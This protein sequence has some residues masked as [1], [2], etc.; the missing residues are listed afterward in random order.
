MD[1]K[2]NSK[3]E[4]ENLQKDFEELYEYL[5]SVLK[6]NKTLSSVFMGITLTAFVFLISLRYPDMLEEVSIIGGIPIRVVGASLGILV[7]SFFFFLTSTMIYHY[8]ELNL[9]R[10]SLCRD[11]KFT[12][13]NRY[14][15]SEKLYKVYY[16]IASISLF[17]GV[18]TLITAVIFIFLYFSVGGIVLTIITF[19]MFWALIGVMFL[20]L[21]IKRHFTKNEKD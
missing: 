21:R 11:P 16:K 13:S 8:C 10:L 18:G 20:Y 15:K 4:V 19:L 14:E 5:K 9:N 2:T 17:Y 3:I 1:S 7:I 12:L 6:I